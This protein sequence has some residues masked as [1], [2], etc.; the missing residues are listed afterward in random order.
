MKL[1]NS[2]K[3]FVISKIKRKVYLYRKLKNRKLH[4]LNIS[5][6]D[7]KASVQRYSTIRNKLISEI[8]EYNVIEDPFDNNRIFFEGYKI[9]SYNGDLMGK[10]FTR[11]GHIYRG[12]YSESEDVFKR[13]WNT[14]I[15]Q[16]LG[17]NELIPK[18]TV[19][20][21]YTDEYPLILEHEVVTMSASKLWNYE[22]VK[23][24]SILIC[25]IQQ[26]CNAFGFKLHDGHLNNVTFNNGHPVFTDIGSI[27]IN[28]GNVFRQKAGTLFAGCYR[29]LFWEVENS[30]L[31]RIQP[32]DELNNTL[33]IE[34]QYYDDQTIECKLILKKYIRYHIIRSSLLSNYLI[35]KMFY[36][37]D[38]RPEYIELLFNAGC[39]TKQVEDYSKDVNAIL[40][41]IESIKSEI[42]K[43]TDIG[44]SAGY[45]PKILQNN[46][47]VEVNCLEH[48]DI[49][50]EMAYN[51]YKEENIKLN[52]Y[53]F[54]YIYGADE[55]TLELIKA[56]LVTAV[57]VTN[58]LSIYQTWKADSLFNDLAKISNKYVAI[59]IHID[60]IK[61]KTYKITD[62]KKQFMM[63]F[64][65][66]YENEFSLEK[67]KNIYVYL[68]RKII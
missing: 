8:R 31:K 38:V 49:K 57:D 44:G 52:T 6:K 17:Q 61:Q 18:T 27:V 42:L 32:Y 40:F 24:A 14:G 65:L 62:I 67:G 58:N 20:N 39:R 26:V 12:I 34:P 36:L 2:T 19:T 64:E 55:K 46:L 66:V 54:N 3:I 1:I 43:I 11:E 63:F 16:V 33:C 51:S 29:L 28:D 15:L 13:L 68:G 23:D 21:Y 30:I 47:S 53:L 56:D 10:V 25:L 48:S 59:T 37:Y 9:L 22:M 5:R 35:F 60:E 50:S 45:I 4:P 7:L 41:A